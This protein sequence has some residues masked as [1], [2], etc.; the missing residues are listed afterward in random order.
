ME[1]EIGVPIEYNADKDFN[2]KVL[3]RGDKQEPFTTSISQLID[4]ERDY[5]PPNPLPERLH[6][7][8]GP[9][10]QNPRD[11]N[12]PPPQQYYEEP[13]YYQ[14]PPPQQQPIIY[15]NNDMF[16]SFDKTVYIG[17]FIAVVLGFFIG[18]NSSQPLIIRPG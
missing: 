16:S 11:Y 13:M 5:V 12:G 8:R 4:N 1:T 15:Q 2:N 6:D 17:L 10:P 7:E 14:Q 18:R 9:I 3:S